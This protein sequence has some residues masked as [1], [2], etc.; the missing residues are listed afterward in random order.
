MA[1]IVEPLGRKR[2]RAGP[3]IGL[4]G[5]PKGERPA[6]GTGWCYG[7]V[8][9]ASGIQHPRRDSFFSGPPEWSVNSEP[10]MLGPERGRARG[11]VLRSARVFYEARGSRG[12]SG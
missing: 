9:R 6:S 3:A 7:R 11:V 10:W 8:G 5:A 2:G 4:N 1:M 12:I